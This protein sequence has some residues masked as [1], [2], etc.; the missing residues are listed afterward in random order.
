ML[1]NV[2][3]REGRGIVKPTSINILGNVYSVEYMN[4]PSD[5]DMYKRQSLWG[6]IDYWTRSIRVYDNGRSTQDLLHTLIHET[7]HGIITALK[8][9]DAKI[10]DETTID[11]FALALADVMTRNGWLKE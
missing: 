4:S 3:G 6:Q 11:V 7:L 8:M 2:Q 5:L 1:A 10:D 9:D